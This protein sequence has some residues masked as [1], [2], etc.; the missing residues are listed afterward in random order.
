MPGVG[1]RIATDHPSRPGPDAQNQL[2]R[3][4]TSRVHP[5]NRL[6]RPSFWLFSENM[7]VMAESKRHEFVSQYDPESRVDQ[8]KLVKEMVAMA[9]AHG[10]TVCLG[11]TDDG[12]RPG[13]PKE[14]VDRLDPAR[15]GDLVQRFVAPDTLDF[16]V[17]LEEADASDR[18]V[19]AIRVES[20]PSP[21]LVFTRAGTYQHASGKQREVFREHSVVIRRHTKAEL[22]TREDFR[23]WRD[24]AVQQERDDWR[25]RVRMI[26]ELPPGATLIE[27]GP[28][29]L[30]DEPAG[31]LRRAVREYR[32]NP[33]KLL[34]GRELLELF[35]VRDALAI[36]D[37]E[38][39]LLVQSALRRKPTLWFW[40]AGRKVGRSEIVDLLQRAIGGSDRDKS[41]AGRAIVEVAA[42]YLDARAYR[43]TVE[44]LADSRYKHFREAA[45][46]FP[47]R[48]AARA[49]LAQLRPPELEGRITKE[50]STEELARF[51]EELA[52]EAL[53]H[54]SGSAL[55]RKMSRVGLEYLVR[56]ERV[57]L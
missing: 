1:Y 28:E 12:R 32:R 15:L 20:F 16:E 49:A 24:E 29:A 57:R 18:H 42:L 46:A 38:F 45:E 39:E 44:Q 17:T 36:G 55:S 23:R 53:S 50:W 56:Q 34:T 27:A 52:R 7:G 35:L 41:D 2:T 54:Q 6:D 11:V 14:V 31:R 13:V 47:T 21:P 25:A 3:N 9:N 48:E 43:R 10:G 40:L 33:E 30:L 51:A 19:V 8:L 4:E 22:A 37:D 5:A 26:A